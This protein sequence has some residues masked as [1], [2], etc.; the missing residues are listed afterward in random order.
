MLLTASFKVRALVGFP[1]PSEDRTFR[2]VFKMPKVTNHQRLT[3]ICNHQYRNPIFLGREWQKDLSESE[4]SS[5]VDLS[6]KMGVSSA[7]A[8]KIQ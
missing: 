4:F 3:K 6:R 8:F 7:S 1:K 2:M 5:R